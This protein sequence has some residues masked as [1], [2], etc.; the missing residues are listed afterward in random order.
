M[1]HEDTLS[2][3]RLLIVD[4]HPMVQSGLQACLSFY[5]D[6]EM[7]GIID[8]GLEAIDATLSIKPDVVLM[9]IS[10]PKL[11]GIDAT[12]I[13]IEQLP[14]VKILVFSMH[15]NPEFVVNAVNAGASGYILKDTSA[16]EVYRAIKVVAAGKSFFSSSV[17]DMLIN[18]PKYNDDSKL[19][20]REQVILA[21]IAKGFSSKEIAQKLNISFR[22]VEAHRRNIKSKLNTETLADMVRYAIA[23]GLVEN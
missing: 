17:A 9:D 18:R 16:E 11:N 3:I 12:E 4:D 2:R 15:E 14:G 8:N 22:T 5:P 10:M 21:H 6:I 1:T 7:V 23:H 19:T 13:I 20:S